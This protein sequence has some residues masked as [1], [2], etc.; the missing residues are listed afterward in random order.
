[1][2]VTLQYLVTGDNFST[3]ALSYRM[4][5]FSVGRIVNE[6]CNVLWKR[7]SEGGFIKQPDSTAE[8]RNI[9]KKYEKY[10]NFPNCVAAIDGK[11]VTIQCPGRRTS[12]YFKYEKFLSIVLLT[13][14]NV[15]YEFSMV[16]IGE[17]GRLSDNSAYA[18]SNLGK[19]INQ[20]L[21]Q[22]P[23]AR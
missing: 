2:S 6:T 21:L 4:S 14:L 17:Y 12:M 13:V 15:Q 16:D 19:T 8:W 18:N 20:N 9:V 22:L 23:S 5:N 1:M 3:I 11:Y 10:W 7:L